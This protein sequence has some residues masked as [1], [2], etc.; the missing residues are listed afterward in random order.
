MTDHSWGKEADC[1]NTQETRGWPSFLID[2]YQQ[3]VSWWWKC[4]SLSSLQ[5]H[6]CL[7]ELARAVW[8][9]QPSPEYLCCQ[10]RQQLNLKRAPSL[11]WPQPVWSTPGG[12]GGHREWHWYHAGAVAMLRIAIAVLGLCISVCCC[13]TSQNQN[14]T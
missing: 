2:S 8:G 3:W 4:S 5:E 6:E 11:S 9:A 1:F 14:P 13:V 12:D 7:P 10:N